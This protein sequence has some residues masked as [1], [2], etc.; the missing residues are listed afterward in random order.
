MQDNLTFMDKQSL[1][2]LLVER[3]EEFACAYMDGK[4]REELDRIKDQIRMIQNEILSRK[5]IEDDNDRP[6]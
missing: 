1:V 5:T 2:D 4:N 6:D 3:T